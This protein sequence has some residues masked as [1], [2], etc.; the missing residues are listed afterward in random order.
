M[1]RS[2]TRHEFLLLAL[3]FLDSAAADPFSGDFSASLDGKVYQLSITGFAS[4]QYDGEYRGE[5]ERL[6]LGARRFGDRIVGQVGVAAT[7]FGFL[8]QIQNGHLLLQYENG[9]VILFKRIAA[10]TQRNPD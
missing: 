3:L 8:G 9:R 10:T 2:R 6:P 1:Q 5:G 4:G 7:R